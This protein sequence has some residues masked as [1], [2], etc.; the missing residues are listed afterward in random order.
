MKADSHRG[1][2]H[3]ADEPSDLR[4]LCDL[5]GKSYPL[6]PIVKLPLWRGT[7][8]LRSRPLSELRPGST[9]GASGRSS[10][11]GLLRAEFSARQQAACPSNMDIRSDCFRRSACESSHWRPRWDCLWLPVLAGCAN[12]PYALQTQNQTLQQQQVALAT[13]QPGTAKPRQH[14]GPR[15][16]GTRNAAGPNAA[17]EQG[18]GRSTGGACAINCPRP[19]RNWR[20]SATKST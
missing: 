10:R 4:V 2:E 14:A 8:S 19:R 12:N 17:A 16:S 15:Q 1:T 6:R 13:A 20:R 11:A 5:C 9:R 7:A 3:T 18:A